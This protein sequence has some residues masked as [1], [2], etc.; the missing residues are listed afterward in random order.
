[1]SGDPARHLSTELVPGRIKP[2]A[3]AGFAVIGAVALAGLALLLT[4]TRLDER[5]PPRE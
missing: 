2:V 4:G 3:L 5:P 1:M